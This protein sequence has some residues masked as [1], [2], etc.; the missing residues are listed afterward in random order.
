MT[1]CIMPAAGGAHGSSGV[2]PA[3]SSGSSGVRP[4]VPLAAAANIGRRQNWFE[5]PMSFVI[6]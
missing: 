4:A 3:A 5:P 2:H 1:G 6:V